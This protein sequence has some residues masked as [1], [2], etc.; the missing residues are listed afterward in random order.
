MAQHGQHG[1]SRPLS[2][3]YS[4]ADRTPVFPKMQRS[5]TSEEIAV[6]A[7]LL[8]SGLPESRE[9]SPEQRE[10]QREQQRQREQRERAREQ[11]RQ[12]RAQHRLNLGRAMVDQRLRELRRAIAAEEANLARLASETGRLATVHEQLPWRAAVASYQ[13]FRLCIFTYANR[14]A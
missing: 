13:A 8:L 5:T 2:D 1:H 10:Q 6:G 12:Q 7:L 11:R 9:P 3:F 14:Q 4:L